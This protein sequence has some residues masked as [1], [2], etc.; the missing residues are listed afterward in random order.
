MLHGG[1][2]RDEHPI[3]TRVDLAITHLPHRVGKGPGADAYGIRTDAIEPIAR[4]EKS[5]LARGPL[6]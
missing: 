6:D 1:H 5:R 2:Q 3:A 4:L